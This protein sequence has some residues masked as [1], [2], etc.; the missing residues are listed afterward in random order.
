[1]DF[2]AETKKL[3]ADACDFVKHLDDREGGPEAERLPIDAA[4]RTALTALAV[5]MNQKRWDTVAEAFVMFQQIEYVR[6]GKSDKSPY[7]M[8]ELLQK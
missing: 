4:M 2:T 1:M 3:Y 5:G 7:L 8:P 6:R